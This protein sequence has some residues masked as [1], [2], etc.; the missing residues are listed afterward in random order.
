M[1]L[2]ENLVFFILGLIFFSV[3]N[4]FFFKNCV[5]FFEKIRM[6]IL[7]EGLFLKGLR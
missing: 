5:K 2:N 4:Y 3:I 7:R 1:S 6:V